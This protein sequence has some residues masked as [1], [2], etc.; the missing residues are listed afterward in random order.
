[1]A[2]EDF[3]ITFI[4]AGP[5]G[6]ENEYGFR[7]VNFLKEQYCSS[8]YDLPYTDDKISDVRLKGIPI[9]VTTFYDLLKLV[10]IIK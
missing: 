7:S 3:T 9:Y 4:A 2:K 5:D 1:M 8:E 6:E 10:G